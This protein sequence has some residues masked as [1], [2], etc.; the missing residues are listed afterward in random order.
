M[1]VHKR[2]NFVLLN[3]GLLEILTSFS[4]TKP[5]FN[6]FWETRSHG[7]GELKF[8]IRVKGGLAMCG[9][10]GLHGLLDFIL[11]GFQKE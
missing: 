6:T 7:R 3:G 1:C 10:H 11:H 2:K 5:A 9:L 4:P 8:I